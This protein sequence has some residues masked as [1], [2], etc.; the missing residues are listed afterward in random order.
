MVHGQTLTTPTISSDGATYSLTI[1]ADT[2]LHSTEGSWDFPSITK[3]ETGT[4]EFQPISST[5]Y[6]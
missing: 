6:S 5:S 2:I 1:K 4:V 3:D